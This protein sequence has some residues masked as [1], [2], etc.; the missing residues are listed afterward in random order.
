MALWAWNMRKMHV[1]ISGRSPSPSVLCAVWY[2]GLAASPGAHTLS[3]DRPLA[4]AG[5]R[6]LKPTLS[7]AAW[8]M[9]SA[10]HLANQCARWRRHFAWSIHLSNP[11]Q[12]M[13]QNSQCNWITHEHLP[14]Q[15]LPEASMRAPSAPLIQQWKSFAAQLQCF[16]VRSSWQVLQVRNLEGQGGQA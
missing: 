2:N 5:M 15:P 12:Q 6:Q 13:K 8:G 4:S 7:A 1:Q 14:S 9:D 11:L 10:L 3:N 16:L